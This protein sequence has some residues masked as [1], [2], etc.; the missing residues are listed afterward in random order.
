MPHWTATCHCRQL[1]L[2]ITGAPR[3]VHACTCTRC[4]NV[5]GGPASWN[6]WFDRADVAIHG[7]YSTYAYDR[8]GSGGSFSTFCPT[9]GSGGFG[10]TQ[11]FLPDCY[12]IPMGSLASPEGPPPPAPAMVHF[13]QNRP[14]WLESLGDLPGGNGGWPDR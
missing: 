3:H 4:Q 6:G 11:E 5:T 13:W 7:T 2:S 8:A 9:C 10:V 12:V 1:R 14:G